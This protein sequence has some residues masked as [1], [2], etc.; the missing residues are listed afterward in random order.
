MIAGL[1]LRILVIKPALL[2]TTD[3]TQLQ[4][5]HTG[6]KNSS[7]LQPPNYSRQLSTTLSTLAPTFV[8]LIDKFTT[9]G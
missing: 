1:T 5:S 7:H 4:T 3:P 9:V 6:D 8:S 2:N